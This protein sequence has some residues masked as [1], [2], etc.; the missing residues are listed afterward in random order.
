MAIVFGRACATG[1][2]ADPCGAAPVITA[3]GSGV[4]CVG[5][6]FS[7]LGYSSG[8]HLSG[9]TWSM[10][11]YTGL[12][13]NASTGVISGTPLSIDTSTIVVTAT[14]GYGSASCNFSI[15][16]TAAPT[17]T[18]GSTASGTVGIS[19]SYSITSS[20]SPAFFNATGLPMGLSVNNLTGAIT[21][22]PILAGTYYVTL[23]AQDTPNCSATGTLTIT[24]VCPSC[25]SVFDPIG[26]I[27]N[28]SYSP[29][30]TI[31]ETWDVTGQC[32]CAWTLNLSYDCNSDMQVVVKV[33]GTTV[34]SG[35]CVASYAG[36][37][38]VPAGST[39]IEVTIELGCSGGST[40]FAQYGIECP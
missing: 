33:D 35:S 13:I 15:T 3:C 14:N 39:T 22:T 27:F 9:V 18:S 19:F 7:A 5:S 37:I 40:T 8:V 6:A 26:N 31:T 25:I 1:A 38:S 20:G 29:H 12:S 24:V 36:T 34:H 11:A 32:P 23:T 28:T 17:I 30:S 16:I 4:G 10:S 21:G 2:C